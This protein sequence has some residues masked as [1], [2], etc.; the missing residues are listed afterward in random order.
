MKLFLILILTI[1]SNIGLAQISDLRGQRYCEVLIGN[2]KLIKGISFDVYN[3]IGLNLCPQEEWEKL[4]EKKIKKKWDAK[5]VKL[6][7][8]RFWTMDSMKST[9]LNPTIVSFNGLEMRKA[10]ILKLG[11]KDIL[12]KRSVYKERKVRRNSIWIFHPQELVY[13]LV[14][15]EGKVY[16]MQSYTTEVKDINLENLKDLKS[17]LKLPRGWDYRARLLSEE[18]NVPIPQGLA[19]VIQDDLHNSYTLIE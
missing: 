1:I 12:G 14:S 9:L 16:I 17:Q 11:I 18:L 13:E 10:G 8:P 15:P 4:S 2:G 3:S 7:G 19:T 6:N 5:F